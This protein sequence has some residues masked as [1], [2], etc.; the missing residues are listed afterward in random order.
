M[1]RINRVVSGRLNSAAS[2][3]YIKIRLI[4]TNQIGSPTKCLPLSIS[5]ILQL[6][7]WIWLMLRN[8]KSLSRLC[9]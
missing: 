1:C 2:A 5:P 9:L 8:S 6:H 4:I 3:S 7:S